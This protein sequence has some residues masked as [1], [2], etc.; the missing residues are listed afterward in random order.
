VI[1]PSKKSPSKSSQ[2]NDKNSSFSCS[3]SSSFGGSDSD[4]SDY[5][6]EE[7]G[8]KLKGFNLQV[9]ED[10]KTEVKKM[11]DSM[12]EKVIEI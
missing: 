5:S 3:D 2:K 7:E 10:Y 9:L 12:E 8:G 11:H 1:S 4:D 6:S